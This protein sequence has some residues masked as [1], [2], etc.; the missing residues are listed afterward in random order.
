M[1]TQYERG[2]LR[3]DDM[4]RDNEYSGDAPQDI[5]T[6]P[7][8]DANAEELPAYQRRSVVATALDRL[9]PSSPQRPI[10]PARSKRSAI[11]TATGSSTSYRSRRSTNLYE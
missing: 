11:A 7:E 8:R 5:K 9:P 3:G 1:E 2:A 6:G 10:S 4:T